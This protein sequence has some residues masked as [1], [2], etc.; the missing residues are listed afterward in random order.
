[1]DVSSETSDIY[2]HAVTLY[3]SNI[4]VPLTLELLRYRLIVM[5]VADIHVIQIATLSYCPIRITFKCIVIGV[6]YN[7]Y[8]CMK[9]SHIIMLNIRLFGPNY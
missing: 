3:D 5:Y 8:C 4:S 9:I 7:V 2:M 6:T 1:M